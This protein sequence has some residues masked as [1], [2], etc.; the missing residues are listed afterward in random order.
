[1]TRARGRAGE[2]GRLSLPAFSSERVAN[3]AHSMR[4]QRWTE[5]LRAGTPKPS[6]SIS[7]R[8]HY[9]VVANRDPEWFDVL[10]SADDL[11]SGEIQTCWFAQDL[12]VLA[13]GLADLART[14]DQPRS[15]VAGGDRA[16]AVRFTGST[17][18]PDHDQIAVEVWMTPNGD[19]PFPALALLL[20]EARREL[21]GA[22][23]RLERLLT[24]SA[25][26][27]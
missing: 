18:I 2:P 21:T 13:A 11:F 25:R 19:D 1:M 27:A 4:P 24:T 10:L 15:F 20:F 9:G 3:L 14:A 17:A 8:P 12:V 6:F 26:E 23:E 5:I 7:A 16:A 22:A